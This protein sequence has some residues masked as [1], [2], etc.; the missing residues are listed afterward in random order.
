MEPGGITDLITAI[1]DPIMALTLFHDREGVF[2][3]YKHSE[4]TAAQAETYGLGQTK[5]LTNSRNTAAV[6][7]IAE[8]IGDRQLTA[9]EVCVCDS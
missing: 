8:Q 7:P 6:I 2:Q 5:M 1:A 9:E 4:D 3:V